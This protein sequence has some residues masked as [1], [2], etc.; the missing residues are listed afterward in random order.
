MLL[1]KVALEPTN[2]MTSDNLGTLFAPHLLMPRR[3]SASELQMAAGDM[4]KMVTFMI[5][6]VDDLFKLPQPVIRDIATYWSQMEE[7]SA[8]SMAD[9]VGS[10]HLQCLGQ[11]DS[12]DPPIYTSVTFADR[13]ASRQAATETDTQM[14][15]AQ[16]YAHISSMP[17]SSK[18]RRLLKQFTK[19]SA[20]S[21]LS[22]PPGT[23][24]KSKKS[25]LLGE[26]IKKIVGRS[27]RRHGSHQSLLIDDGIRELANMPLA[28]SLSK[29]KPRC[30][31]VID[32]PSS[33]RVHIV[34]MKE[35][36][37]PKMAI[38]RKIKPKPSSLG[39]VLMDAA[40]YTSGSPMPAF[41]RQ[42]MTSHNLD[43]TPLEFT[44]KKRCH[45]REQKSPIRRTPDSR[46]ERP[47]AFVSPIT[48]TFN[49]AS[50]T[51]KVTTVQ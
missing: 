23:D 27:H 29:P 46:F 2:K 21:H 7:S 42:F 40:L 24:E 3:M 30:S 19:N 8:K 33:P 41:S 36:Q 11:S 35:N 9:D 38:H 31:R 20:V 37:D 22:S 14:A 49:K 13:Q 10:V 12:S 5:D 43:G 47:I 25:K 51:T 34:D 44:S 15:L 48:R 50:L 26:S 1:H 32:F 18:K 4:S 28:V 17:S 6:N 39:C 45:P 16:L